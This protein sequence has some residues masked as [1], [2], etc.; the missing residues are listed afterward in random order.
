[1]TTIEAAS[2]QLAAAKR[3]LNVDPKVLECFDKTGFD[4]S[5]LPPLCSAEELAAAVRTTVSALAQDRYLRRGMP[6]TKVGRRVLYSRRMVA[7]HLIDHT[8]FGR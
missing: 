5:E 8:H 3:L 7:Q 4:L 2:V 6:Y 1:M